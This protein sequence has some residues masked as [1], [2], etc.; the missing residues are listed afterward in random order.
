MHLGQLS[1]NDSTG[2]LNLIAAAS[3][4]ELQQRCHCKCEVCCLPSRTLAGHRY[5]AKP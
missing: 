4:K 3:Q 5:P 2:D 1:D